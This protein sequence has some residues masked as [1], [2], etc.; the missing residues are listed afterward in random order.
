MFLGHLKTLTMEY[1]TE[2]HK[3]LDGVGENKFDENVETVI[4]NFFKFSMLQSLHGSVAD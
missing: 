2:E 3:K 4:Y 1:C